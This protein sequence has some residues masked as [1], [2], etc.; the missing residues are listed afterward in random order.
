[1][2]P[3]PCALLILALAVFTGCAADPAADKPDATVAE[4][5]PDAAPAADGTVLP[6]NE[7]S[8]IG[9]VGSKVTGSHTG[10]F[11]TFEGHVNLV[12]NDPTRSSVNV[13]IDVNSLWSDTDKLT[14][15]LKSPDFFDVA[16]YPTAT[17]ESTSIVAAESGYVATGNLNLHGVEK[18]VSFPVEIRVSDGS[19]EIHASFSIK[20]FDFGI[21]YAGPA[22]NLIRDEVAI[23]LD[24]QA[25]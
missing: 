21:E 14:G 25:G 12:D 18:S 2:R 5:L 8:M 24:L 22:D 11:H 19:V 4:P 17:F 7:G 23:T 9:W 10:G 6:F 13:T 15:H 1:M 16:T 20:R 3:L